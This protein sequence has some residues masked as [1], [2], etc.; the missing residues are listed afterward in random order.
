MTIGPG[1]WRFSSVLLW[2]LLAGVFAVLA[3]LEFAAS[4]PAEGAVLLVAPVGLYALGSVVLRFRPHPI[5]LE[6]TEST[7][8]AR[9][10]NWRGAPDMEA[11][12][13]EVRSIHYFP[14]LISFRGVDNSTS[15]MMI[16]PQYS[17]RQMRKIATELHVR[18]YDHTR[19]LGLGTIDAGRLAYDPAPAPTRKA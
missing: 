3:V 18:L 13:S 11:P 4:Q 5:R 10:G 7:V 1:F 12:R 19:W 8:R 2:A 17:L 9:Q 15:L 16:Q 14:K 6:I